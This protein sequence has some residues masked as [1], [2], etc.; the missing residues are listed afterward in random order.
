MARWSPTVT[1]MAPVASND[2]LVTGISNGAGALMQALSQRRQEKRADKKWAL[3]Q[4]RLIDNEDVR[5]AMEMDRNAKADAQQQLQNALE[6]TRLRAELQDRGYTQG[7]TNADKMM[8]ASKGPDSGAAPVPMS[9]LAG[10]GS[11]LQAKT[12]TMTL[13][14]QIGGGTFRRDASMDPRE[15]ARAD[16]RLDM[17]ARQN[18]ETDQAQRSASLQRELQANQIAASKSLAAL[19]R[20]KFTLVPN[21]DGTSSVFDTR[22]GTIREALDQNGNPVH[23]K[24]AKP[25]DVQVLAGG[26]ARR[27][28][29]AARDLDTFEKAG[30]NPVR[31]FGARAAGMVPFVGDAMQNQ[32]TDD[33]RQKYWTAASNWVRANLRKESGAAIGKDEMDK[34]I[35]TYFPQSGDSPATIEYKRHLRELTT[36]NMIKAAG[37]AFNPADIAPVQQ[38]NG[39]TDARQLGAMFGSQRGY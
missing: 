35:S 11:Q 26:F 27:M 30:N 39:I 34:E 37:N 20:D 15:Q 28:A 31:S 32:L 10:L 33:D 18:F 12:Q 21:A 38:S 5:Q 7:E 22:T 4:Q 24:G 16:R 23:G 8:A 29:E 25:T 19:A 13:P 14:S 2:A 6:G 9:A 1:P 36:Q 3:E 17:L